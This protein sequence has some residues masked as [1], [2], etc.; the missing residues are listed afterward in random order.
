MFTIV[1]SLRIVRQ[2]DVAVYEPFRATRCESSRGGRNGNPTSAGSLYAK[3]YCTRSYVRFLSCAPR[4]LVAPVGV[5]L[6]R[7]PSSLSLEQIELDHLRRKVEKDLTLAGS[8]DPARSFRASKTQVVELIQ[9]LE[10]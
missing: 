8:P 3:P 10:H 9:S 7:G 4:T 1:N 5:Q 6:N 2:R